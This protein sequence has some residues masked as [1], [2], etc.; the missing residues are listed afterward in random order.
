LSHLVSKLP[1][2]HRETFMLEEEKVALENGVKLCHQ[3]V[4]DPK[5]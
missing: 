3:A 2:N 5:N 1:E 4:M